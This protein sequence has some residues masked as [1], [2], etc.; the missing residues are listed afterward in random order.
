MDFD[1]FFETI[2]NGF[3][4]AI[5]GVLIGII[6]TYL[7][8][9]AVVL[10]SKNTE[11]ATLRAAV[12]VEKGRQNVLSE[13]IKLLGDKSVFLESQ[14]KYKPSTQKAMEEESKEKIEV[15]T[16][17]NAQLHSI[18][19]NLEKVEGNKINVAE[20]STKLE[21]YTAENTQLK[22]QLGKFTSET[23]VSEYQMSKGES[24]SGLGG[25]VTFGISNITNNYKKGNIAL[26]VSSIFDNDD[27]EIQA[28]NRFDFRVA[29]N[30][31]ILVVNKVAYI[32][33]YV[34]ISVQKKI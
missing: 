5:L 3:K 9:D 34:T 30:D 4:P 8:Y 28:G 24:W 29:D 7:V 18:K 19:E 12:D 33:D 25:R 22:I 17:E 31:Y 15:L 27:K 13:R 14:L 23:L 32:G 10:A 2:S 21:K 1:K 26:A 11:L 20:L 16:R 6:G